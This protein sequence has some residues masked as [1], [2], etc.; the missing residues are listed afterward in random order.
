MD[1][2]RSFGYGSSLGPFPV[3]VWF[4]LVGLLLL[5]VAAASAGMKKHVPFLRR[6]SVRAHR[7]IATVG[8]LLAIVHLL[9]GLSIY[10]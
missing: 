7:L 2:L 9:M 4:G 10:I 6:V 8:L 3:V 5:V 1:A